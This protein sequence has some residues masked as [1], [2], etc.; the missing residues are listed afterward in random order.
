MGVRIALFRRTE[1]LSGPVTGARLPLPHGWIMN[2]TFELVLIGDDCQASPME[3]GR[4]EAS[5]ISGRWILALRLT[6]DP[7]PGATSGRTTRLCTSTTLGKNGVW[8][9]RVRLG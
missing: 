9:G 5:V 3:I 2:E 4:P 1:P 8:I 7:S 6:S